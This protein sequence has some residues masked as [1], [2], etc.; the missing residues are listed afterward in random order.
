M[1]YSLL[2]RVIK[3]LDRIRTYWPKLVQD[4]N[5][6]GSEMA[7]IEIAHDE[8]SCNQKKIILTTK[9]EYFS[10]DCFIAELATK[11][12]ISIIRM[13]MAMVNRTCVFVNDSS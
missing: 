6:E 2:T 11:T 7:T 3:N 12:L 10:R 5:A 8:M 9:A 13:P 1:L 4:E